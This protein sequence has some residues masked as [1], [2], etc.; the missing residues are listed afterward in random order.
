MC[1]HVSVGEISRNDESGR[2]EEEQNCLQENENAY[3]MEKEKLQMTL[4][5]KEAATKATV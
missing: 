4:V 5:V 1:G 2:V 3:E